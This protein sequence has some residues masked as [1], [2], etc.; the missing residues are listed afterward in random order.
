MAESSSPEPLEVDDLA[1][2]FGLGQRDLV[3]S[4]RIVNADDLSARQVALC[5]AQASKLVT[6]ADLKEVG[7]D[8]ETCMSLADVVMS[9]CRR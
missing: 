7:A 8:A 5:M 4:S 3:R 1:K 2:I 6:A 9:I